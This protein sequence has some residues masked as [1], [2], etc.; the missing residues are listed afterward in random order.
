M[1]GVAAES[2]I[3]EERSQFRLLAERRFGPFF[4]TQFLGAFNDNVFKN[5]LIVFIAF[6][7]LVASSNDVN[8]LVNLSAALFILPFF[9]FSATFGQLAEKYEKSA[10]IRA[11]KALEVMIMLVAAVGFTLKSVPLLLAVLFLMGTQSTLFGPVKYSILPQQLGP[12]ELVGGNGLVESGTFLAILLGT[13]LGGLAIAVQGSGPTLVAGLVVLIA[14]LGYLASRAIPPS[15]ATAPD[16]KVNWN[17]FTETWRNLAFM[18]SH[19]TVFLSVLGISWFWFL[20]ATYLAQLPN[21]TRLSLGGNEQVVTLL[22]TLFSFGVGAGSLLC[23]RMSGHTVELGLVPFGSIGLTLFGVDL[24]FARPG[25]IGPELAGA[26]EFLAQTG[27]WRI[28]ADILLM[29]VFGGFYIVPLYA[30]VQQRSPAE[31]RSRVIAG[32]NIL[33]ALFMVGSALLAI[34][35]LGVGLSLPE[36]LLVAALLNAAVAIYIYTLVPEFLMRFL[37]WIIV[38]L[39]YR[40]DKEGLDNIPDRGPA[41]LI[42]NHVSFMDALILAGCCRRPIRFVM[43][44]SIFRIPLL[45]FIF[46][47]AKAIAIAP[48][49]VDRRMLEGAYERVADALANDELVCIFPE[50]EIT[51]DGEM[52]RF[53]PG[54]QRIVRESPVPVIP[55]AMQ[56][57]WGSFFSRR[58][59]PAM[60]KIPRRF[61]SRIGL[62][63]GPPVSATEVTAELMQ[64][65][66]LALRGDRR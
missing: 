41:V 56:G 16:L 50:G 9:L 63:A 48:A 12:D 27:S 47:T 19:R 29:G 46:K 64:Q 24:Y 57:L 14:V 36:L 22:L 45:R 38:H 25:A 62:V 44:Y 33:N 34:G 4:L 42:C 66:V 65:Q 13:L 5:A 2:R 23:E 3:H 52:N 20:G 32:N 60:M 15:P 7:T 31:H 17:P 49:K 6:G 40:I 61:F 54:V 39:M 43:H 51:H 35:M 18:S 53:R 37:V 58:Y 59:G 1:N 10:L 21:Y 26:L 11:V 55:M 30:L 8:V 28:A